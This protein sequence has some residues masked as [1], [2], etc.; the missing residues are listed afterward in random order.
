MKKIYNNNG[1]NKVRTLSTL[2]NYKLTFLLMLI[3]IS[4]VGFTQ[5]TITSL[6]PTFSSTQLTYTAAGVA[7]ACT[8]PVFNAFTNSTTP[9]DAARGASL[10]SG[11]LVYNIPAASSNYN[12]Y[13]TNCLYWGFAASNAGGFNV[14]TGAISNFTNSSTI[15]GVGGNELIFTQAIAFPYYN[16]GAS[17]VTN[18]SFSVR[19]RIT[20]SAGTWQQYGSGA[21][22]YY[23]VGPITTSAITATVRVEGLYNGFTTPVL[24]NSTL[25]TQG[26]TNWLPAL[27]IYNVINTVSTNAA[28]TSINASFFSISKPTMSAFTQTI[29]SG[30]KPNITL[31]A[32]PTT[33]NYTWSTP[34]NTN[35][36]GGGAQSTQSSILDNSSNTALTATT[37]SP[38]TA[39]Y[40]VTAYTAINSSNLGTCAS[41]TTQTATINVNPNPSGVTG[42]PSNPTICTSTSPNIALTTNTSGGTN[43]FYWTV[44]NNSPAAGGTAITSGTTGTTSIN[45]TL[46][47]S[48]TA[49]ATVVY[50]VTPRFTANS[51]SCIGSAVT[52]TVTVNPKP[53]VTPTPNNPYICPNSSPNIALSNNTTGGTNSW[54]W[55]GT[56]GTNV[57]GASNST[58]TP[59]NQTLNNTGTSNSTATYVITPT[60]TYNSVSCNGN[61]NTQTVTIYP[62]PQKPTV[63][64]STIDFTA[65]FCG[66]GNLTGVWD[67]VNASTCKFYSGTY[68]SGTFLGSGASRTISSAGNY[69]VTSYNTTTSCESD[70]IS[71]TVTI[72]S[73]FSI[74]TTLSNYNGYNISCYGGTN[75]SV[76]VTAATTAYPITYTW[77]TGKTTTINSGTVTD[78]ITGLAAGN[79]AVTISDA[80]GCSNS[81]SITLTQP[82]ALSLSL[83]P[84]NFSGYGT[85]CNGSSTGSITTTPS[86]GYGSYGYAWTSTPAGYTSASGNISSL[87]ARTYN[88]TVTDGNGCTIT[89][90][91]VITDPAVIAFTTATGY[92]CS[93][94]TYT[95]ATVTVNATGGA[96]GNYQYSM[97]GGTWQNSNQFSGLANGSS[98]TF[99]VRDLNNP[100]CTSS[101]QSVGITFPPSGT[102][103][104]DCNFIYVT[105]S[106][107][108]SGTLGSKACPVTLDAAFAIFAGNSARNHILMAAGSYTYNTTITIPGGVIIDGGYDANTWIKQTSPTTILNINPGVTENV[109]EGHYKGIVLGGN[110]IQ[111]LDLTINVLSAGAPA[112][113]YTANSGRSVYG[114]YSNG[115]TGFL[116]SRCTVTTGAASGG[117]NGATLSGTG[118]GG[119]GGAGGGGG[120][121]GG[122]RQCSGNPYDGGGGSNGS[123]G[124]GGG[125]GGGRCYASGCSW[126]SGYNCDANGCTAGNGNPGTDGSAGTSYASGNR[127]SNSSGL[128]S[129]FVPVNGVVGGNGAGGG[130]GGGGGGA[131]AGTCCTSSCPSANPSGGNGGNGGDGGLGGNF[132]YGGGSSI[133]IYVWG[134]TGTLNDVALGAGTA[135]AGGSGSNGK[136]GVGGSQ[137]VAGVYS[138]GGSGNQGRGGTGGTGGTG[139]AGGR[140]QDGAN[141][142]SQGLVTANSASVPQTGTSV[143]NDGTV[144]VNWNR[145]CTKSQ[146]DLTKTSA[147]SWVGISSDPAFVLNSTNS[148]TSYT[149]SMNNVSVYYTSIGIKNISLGSTALANFIRI[150]GARLVDP[151]ASVMATIT[152][153]QICPSS[154][155]NL[156]NTLSGGAL[157]NIVEWSWEIA[158]VSNPFN[159]VYTSSAASPGTVV[160][161]VG[162]WQPG[163]TY[164]VRLKMRE[165]CCGWSIP[166]Y[167]TFTISPVLAQP[168][169]TANP[170]T[171]VCAGSTVQYTASTIGATT[172]TWSVTGGT[173]SAGPT[174]DIINVTWPTATTGTV[175]V[176]PKNACSPGTDGPVKVINV[177]VNA[178]PTVSISNP[179]PTICL[180]SSTTLTA[181]SSS[182]G[183]AGIGTFTYVWTPGGSTGAVNTLTVAPTPA[184]AYNYTV[185]VTENGSGCKATSSAITVVSKATLTATPASAV[186]GACLFGGAQY[187]D[188]YAPA[189]ADPTNVTGIWSVTGSGTVTSPNS[190]NTQI[191]GIPISGGTT[192]VNWS[193]GYNVA[194]ACTVPSGNI[195]IVAPNLST[196]LNS[197]SLQNTGA[198]ATSP[199]PSYY[200]CAVCSLHDGN[201]YT[202][203]DAVGK[204]IA[205]I[206][207]ISN[208]TDLGNTEV[209]IGYDY[210]PPATPHS[211][212]VETIIDNFGQV[213]PYLPR[214]WTI[215]P[216]GSGGIG[217]AATVTLYFTAAEYNALLTRAATTPYLFSGLDLA[218]TKYPGGN[219]GGQF[220]APKSIGGVFVPSTF[221]SY[222][223][224]Y[225]V[226]FDVSSFST[227]YVHPQTYP[228]AALPIELVSF[229]GW[230]E[231]S[232]NKL[233]WITA[234]ELNTSK[235]DVQKRNYDGT[236]MSIGEKPAA[237]NSNARLVYDFTDN[238]PVVGSNYYRI[239]VI[240]N[241]GTFSFTDMINIQIDEVVVNN[242]SRLYPNPTG[243][244]LNVEIQATGLTDTK[245]SVYDIVGQS[246]FEKN[247][248]LVK[249]LNTIVFDFNQLSKGTYFLRYVDISGNLHTA[250]FVK[251]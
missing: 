194:P 155:I 190:N 62:K 84:S 199:K 90:S 57:S 88:V 47:N 82:T 205:K 193:V 170:N 189:I 231:G 65:T 122:I 234:S 50:S 216:S 119:S 124:A 58:G 146:I 86:G 224:D 236:W 247:T 243:G 174:P 166:I 217:S 151:A 109:S 219:G 168:T 22:A 221:S 241:D 233:E 20:L 180:P 48:G 238:N 239:K 206:S 71:V 127:P 176:I 125:S 210:A 41:A 240:D 131:T 79:Y 173:Y 110:N 72:T 197:V 163:A 76:T 36:S 43:D 30:N 116:I 140:G 159:N 4:L 229:T 68:P 157:S 158:L 59:I 154:S 51:L 181:N 201:T 17:P 26:G 164:Q 56:N 130:G 39:V 33:S 42:T 171:T 98:H 220:I 144:S 167:Q 162:G 52:Q 160:A 184:G 133:P 77:S 244:N 31:S 149:A 178:N 211:G 179:T 102:S 143:P 12:D 19:M 3:C 69:Y 29:C 107:D 139:G 227:F 105:N 136:S 246:V 126:I 172:Y 132:G 108:P 225:Q 18:N 38:G 242:F 161:P 46:S 226:S 61:T 148:T 153:N 25:G 145:G 104:G 232:V 141:G 10:S 182:G 121:G 94:S 135:G 177:S 150:Y 118:G 251:D 245:I 70:P 106:G 142:I 83:V 8:S 74:S 23:L 93:G 175:S 28:Y 191:T 152:P 37:T 235:Y 13:A 185:Q 101:I 87:S 32:S 85:S 237:G 73:P 113:L 63:N 169:I 123:G 66:S 165:S 103:V 16:G 218:V 196:S 192:V 53:T 9:T 222:N 15:S 89:G 213:Q 6:T 248:T 92:A 67:P 7:S 78:N 54:S 138:G 120:N 96:S 187:A 80:G 1:S 212:N 115:K 34:T 204:I 91:S 95:S 228:F 188:L 40:N 230:N 137:G 24:C 5:T 45:Q 2:L 147:S 97:D 198:A 186:L 129:F 11:G 35:V 128:Q 203:Y 214:S 21:S 207:D 202:F 208:S 112:G 200:T 14:G 55:T 64:G 249:G 27:Q 195:S 60:Y 100:G 81:A 114:I 223:S 183:G 75:G 250:K 134:G 117:T 209:C 215:K 99:Q 111:L 49:P 156:A 44:T